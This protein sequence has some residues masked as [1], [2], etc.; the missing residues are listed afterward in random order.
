MLM[1]A[2]AGALAT[3][4][5]AAEQCVAT[6]VDATVLKVID[7]QQTIQLPLVSAGCQSRG[8]CKVTGVETYKTDPTFDVVLE[9]AGKQY[10][11]TSPAAPTGKTMAVQLEGCG[12]DRKAKLVAVT[13]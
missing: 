4:A 9:V 5:Q 10:T 2:A 8:D 12:A 13:H 1:L 7:R 11:V 3:S 6:T